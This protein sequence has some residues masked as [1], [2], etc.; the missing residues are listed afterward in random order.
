[1]GRV[2]NPD[3]LEDEPSVQYELKRARQNRW[4]DVII[5]LILIAAA[6]LIQELRDKRTISLRLSQDGTQLTVVGADAAEHVLSFSRLE[7]VEL[8]SGL[9]ELDRGE[10]LGGETTKT[11]TSGRFR[12]EAYGE[13]EL[14][15]MNKLHDYIVARG[16]D[17]TLVFNY[18][19]DETTRAVYQYICE[20]LP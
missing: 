14:H 4:R 12:S 1:M 6:L 19:S 2:E 7:S 10:Q 11:L 13:Y 16:A 18:E 5:C 3:A 15:V 8:L 9:Q 17:G 20:K